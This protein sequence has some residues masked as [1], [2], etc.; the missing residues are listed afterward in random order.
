MEWGH[1]V[2][3]L[4]GLMWSLSE[5]VIIAGAWLLGWFAKR[6]WMVIVG[7]VPI[8]GLATLVAVL[9]RHLMAEP[10]APSPGIATQA[11][12]VDAVAA[13]AWSSVAFRL[14][15][16]AREPTGAPSGLRKGRVV[17]AAFGSVAGSVI[18][19]LAQYLGMLAASAFG[20]TPLLAIPASKL[21]PTLAGGLVGWLVMR[22]D[23]VVFVPPPPP[24][25]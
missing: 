4:S 24:R 15:R 11:L 18:G 17:G 3:A 23:P 6:W 2:I 7:V 21:L 12:I 20:V 5:T 8:V 16:W 10:G 1:A 14:A 25:S 19:L 13:L 9:I 22:R